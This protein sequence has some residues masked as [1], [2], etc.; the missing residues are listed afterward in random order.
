MIIYKE[1]K[2]N[3]KKK[4]NILV[5]GKGGS[6]VS[7]GQVIFLFCFFSFEGSKVREDWLG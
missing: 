2:S 6:E 5:G 4:K 3:Q 1:S 7:L